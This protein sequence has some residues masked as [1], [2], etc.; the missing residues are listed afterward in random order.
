MLS[1]LAHTDSS[2]PALVNT[3]FIFNLS[4]RAILDR[5]TKS[6]L[7]RTARKSTPDKSQEIF[8]RA[9]SV[10]VM[11]PSLSLHSV[12]SLE[13]AFVRISYSNWKKRL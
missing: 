3:L 1:T 2:K 9:T 12:S 4:Q 11:D 8:N 10:L 6:P 13:E 7:D 5:H